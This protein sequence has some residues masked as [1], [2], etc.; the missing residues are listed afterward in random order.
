[1]AINMER[2][3]AR[4]EALQNRGS[5][6]SNKEMF[7][8]PQDGETTIRIVPTEDGDPFKD[9]WFHY[10]VGNNPGFLS[11]KK[12]FGE[13]D[14]LDDFVRSLFKEGS[15]DSIKMAKSLMARQRFFAP[16]L[17]RGEE[18]KGVR[19]WGFGKMA[20]QE[21]LNLVLNPDYGDIT[22]VDD[23]TDL[24]ITY[25]KPPGAQ[26]PQTTI[27]PRRKSSALTTSKKQT[28]EYL[29][30]VPDFTT[31]F[32]KKSPGQVQEMLDQFLL[33]EEDAEEVSS[34]TKKYKTD[35]DTATSVDQAFSEFLG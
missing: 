21:L 12:N 24:V 34:E 35:S 15:E 22:D 28:K 11:P 25:G 18:D 26:F 16:V 14:P 30:Q 31:L 9:F 32:E 23:G 5:G 27:T 6:G 1:M 2:M 10:N 3:K 7:W 33:G 8:R 29:E 17:V 19:V 13:D 4:R 20:Y